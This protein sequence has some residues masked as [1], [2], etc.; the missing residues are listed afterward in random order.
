MAAPIAN[1]RQTVMM[2][3][4]DRLDDPHREIL[5]CFAAG[6]DRDLDQPL[7]SSDIR[8]AVG[9]STFARYLSDLRELS[10]V[11]E[12]GEFVQSDGEK[13]ATRQ[14]RYQ[15]TGRGRSLVSRHGPEFDPKQLQ[16][17]VDPEPEVRSNP[18]PV[19]RDP[20]SLTDL[21]GSVDAFVQN[22]ET[23]VLHE[24][25]EHRPGD[26][27]GTVE[28]TLNHEG[29]QEVIEIPA[30]RWHNSGLNHFFDELHAAFGAGHDLDQREWGILQARWI[31]MAEVVDHDQEDDGRK[32][33]S[34]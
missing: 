28:I 7:L 34:D 9:D 29:L 14:S 10:L 18:E 16:G 30:V 3:L 19:G 33:V 21:S 4:L 17:E 13:Q 12:I 15:L 25:I 22:T 8:E 6:E 2:Q 26:P 11:T 1:Q 5:R 20:D 24:G 23:V 32:E 31:E 27:R